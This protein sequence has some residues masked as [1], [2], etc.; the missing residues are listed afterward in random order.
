VRIPAKRLLGSWAEGSL[1]K[2]LQ[3]DFHEEL[4]QCG[5]LSLGAKAALAGAE[6]ASA[7]SAGRRY[8][9]WVEKL[10]N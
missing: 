3:G 10:F 4:S 1:K 6:T 8:E 7:A 9:S 5:R 2:L